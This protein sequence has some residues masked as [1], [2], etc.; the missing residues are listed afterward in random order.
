MKKL[1]L[2]I[3]ISLLS[4]GAFSQIDAI[5]AAADGVVIAA[6]ALGSSDACCS[7][8]C[9]LLLFDDLIYWSIDGLINHHIYIMDH[10]EDF[11][12]RYSFEYMSH[13]AADGQNQFSVLQ[14]VRGTVGIIS[15]DFRVNILS[16]I[17]NL[18]FSTYK[19]FDW[20]IINLNFR[21]DQSVEF[22]LGSGL[23][24]DN[25]SETFYN[26]H[27]AS[28]GF[29]LLNNQVHTVMEGRYT[30]SYIRQYI[31]YTELSLRNQVHLFTMGSLHT[32][33]MIGGMYQSYYE[34]AEYLS[35]QAG[36][37]FKVF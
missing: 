26:Q 33:F 34:V 23:M 1:I 21:P 18:N 9:F 8:P 4:F 25:Y 3:L 11:P 14:R 36:L 29:H 15:S 22:S 31:V 2:S 7:D 10:P 5:K 24:Y 20:Q 27:Y 32:Y 19:T 30:P 37:T 16:E 13:F 12:D 6:D 35:L 28:L 17:Q